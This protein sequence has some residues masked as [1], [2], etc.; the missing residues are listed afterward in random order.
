MFI[1][2]QRK[3]RRRLGDLWKICKICNCDGGRDAP[4][5]VLVLTIDIEP[6][7]K[8]RAS[9]LP[10]LAIMKRKSLYEKEIVVSLYGYIIQNKC[11]HSLK[12][13]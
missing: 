13:F 10:L 2:G 1:N 3:A 12:S 6:P 4:A 7:K 8:R 11:V 9:R 5:I